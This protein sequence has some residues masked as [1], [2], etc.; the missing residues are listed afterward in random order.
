MKSTNAGKDNS[1][2]RSLNRDMRKKELVKITIEN[3]AILRRLQDKKSNYNHTNWQD[4]RKKNER[5]LRNI[6]EYPMTLYTTTSKTP[7]SPDEVRRPQTFHDGKIREDKF[8][9]NSMYSNERYLSAPSMQN[10]QELQKRH[11]KKLDP[12]SP[13]ANQKEILYQTRKKNWI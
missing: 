13:M 11:Q 6:S 9:L 7:K 12:M 8:G 3:Q 4:E 2:P 5:Y 1:Q 10:E